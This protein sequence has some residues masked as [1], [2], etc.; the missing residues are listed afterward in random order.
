VPR[1]DGTVRPGRRYH[2]RRHAALDCPRVACA[3]FIAQQKHV[4][5]RTAS[6]RDAEEPPA[7]QQEVGP[8]VALSL[9]IAA[10]GDTQSVVCNRC[11]FGSRLVV[12]PRLGEDF[13]LRARRRS[14][15]HHNTATIKLPPLSSSVGASPRT[16]GNNARKHPLDEPETPISQ[17][18]RGIKTDLAPSGG[19]AW[20]CAGG[21]DFHFFTQGA[22]NNTG[23]MYEPLSGDER[24][25]QLHFLSSG[26]RRDLTRIVEPSANEMRIVKARRQL[27]LHSSSGYPESHKQ[28]KRF[29]EFALATT[30]DA[31]ETG[32]C[33]ETEL[34]RHVEAR[35]DEAYGPKWK[36]VSPPARTSSHLDGARCLRAR[37]HS[38]PSAS[39]PPSAQVLRRADG[40]FRPQRREPP[41]RPP[42][43]PLLCRPAARARVQGAA[44]RA[45]RR[46]ARG[47][48]CTLGG[49]LALDHRTGPRSK[50][51]RLTLCEHEAA[52]LLTDLLVPII[53]PIIGRWERCRAGGRRRAATSVQITLSAA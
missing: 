41:P 48:R 10:H 53:V 34:A 12:S 46:Q 40:G 15:Q 4:E 42:A 36:C 6:R 49:G 37:P 1:G 17:R 27:Q 43:R 5:L 50:P 44:A 32:L 52:R 20:A 11:V 9:D 25:R 24:L 7:A 3:K 8:C 28:Q 21:Y 51:Q 39:R 38:H 45:A 29:D 26:S 47:F 13:A 2:V 31:L 23:A 35:F 14:L 19:G 18:S 16:E 22:R 30:R 33:V